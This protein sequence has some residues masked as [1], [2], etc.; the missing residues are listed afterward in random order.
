MSDLIINNHLIDAPIVTILKEV[1]RQTGN[2]YLREIL[3]KG[4]NVQITCPH[5]SGGNE[6]EPSCGVYCGNDPDVE[7][8]TVNCFTCGFK[9]PLFLLVS[10]CFGKDTEWAKQWLVDNFSTTLIEKITG[11]PPIELNS[12]KKVET[13]DESYLDTLQ[14]FHPYMTKRKLNLKVCEKFKVKYEPQ[15]QCLV[16][17][18][19]DEFNNLVML[20]RRSVLNKRFIIDEGKE[21]PIYLYNFIKYNNIEEVTICESQINALTLWGYGIPAIATFGCSVTDKQFNILNRSSIK[22]YFIAY[23]G[24]DAGIKGT[25]KLIRNLRNDV[26][27]DVILLPRGKDIND[28]TEEEFNSLPIVEGKEWLLN[29]KRRIV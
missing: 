15:S 20:T 29:Q 18:V 6:S 9:G 17:P 22:H 7:Y 16:F 12:S 24:D 25:K 13:L 21:K 8:G 10:E 19:W 28:L 23:D 26:F 27:V 11:L 3:P 4:E 14:S 2:K 5:H 1:R